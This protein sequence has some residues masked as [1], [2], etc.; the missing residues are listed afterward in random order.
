MQLK[1]SAELWERG[2]VGFFSMDGGGRGE[3]KRTSSQGESR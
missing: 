1:V 2:S 3:T